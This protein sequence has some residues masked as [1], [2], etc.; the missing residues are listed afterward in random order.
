MRLRVPGHRC[1]VWIVAVSVAL[2]TV[3]SD[4][5]LAV[6]HD[7]AMYVR[8]TL[9]AI[10]K[11]A[12]GKFD[13]Q[14][15]TE[16][17]FRAGK[18]GSVAIPYTAIASLEFEQKETT[19]I[20]IGFG[21]PVSKQLAFYLTITYSDPEGKKQS[22]VFELGRDVVL[23]LMKVLETRS[24]KTIAFQDTVTCRMYKTPQECEGK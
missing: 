7:K 15:E 12:Q 10:E 2:A 5:V 20:I 17:A 9:S 18:K 4:A 21:P 8:G 1:V 19:A 13:T 23:G 6:G 22:G 14:S 11:R 16:L 24:G 3:L